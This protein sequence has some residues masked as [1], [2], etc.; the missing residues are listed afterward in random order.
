MRT[1]GN[2]QFNRYRF[3]NLDNQ[4]AQSRNW[5][6]ISDA[7]TDIYVWMREFL[8]SGGPQ[9]YTLV[10][11]TRLAHSRLGIRK[12]AQLATLIMSQLELSRDELRYL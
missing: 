3:M 10:A 8:H 7:P 4:A 1:E 6:E 9:I 2:G 11:E 12:P 5:Y